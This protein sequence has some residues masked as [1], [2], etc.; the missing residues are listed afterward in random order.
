MCA[1]PVGVRL[2]VGADRELRDVTV[3]RRLGEVEADVAAARAALLRGDERQVDRVRHEVG[4]E[5]EALGLVLGR[6]VVRLAVEAALEVVLGA[7][8]EIQVLVE[9]DDDR[10]VGH[11][12]EPRRIAARAVE[13]LM[14]A[15]QRNGEQ[16][17]GLPL[18]GDALAGVVP[19]RGRAAARQD[20]DGLFEQLPLRRQGLARR[21]LADVA[22]VRGARRLV[23]HEHAGAAAPRP[24]LQFDGVEIL[25]VGRA[26]QVEPLALHP[27][28]VGRLFFG[29]EFLREL[30][31]NDGVLGH[32][33]SPNG[34]QAEPGSCGRPVFLYVERR[35]RICR[36]L[37]SPFRRAQTLRQ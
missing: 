14:H 13:V 36:K 8:D 6:E 7:E 22:V 37:P 31:G 24:G 30:V 15:V 5:Q 2:L 29:R 35:S 32:G 26:D 1:R 9:I 4:G 17:A 11:R 28:G 20:H 12:D 16:R 21:D 34:T 3:Q 25:H 19:H 23:V 27:A 33:S 10:R 18:E